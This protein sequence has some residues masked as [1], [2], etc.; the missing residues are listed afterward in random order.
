MDVSNAV[1]PPHSTLHASPRALGILRGV[2]RSFYLTLRVLPKSIRRPIGLAYLLARAADTIADTA[3]I[4]PSRRLDELERL[5]KHILTQNPDSLQL[6]SFIQNQQNRNEAHLLEQI[7]HVIRQFEALPTSDQ[8][9][10]REVLD[11]ITSGQILDL[12]RFP[13]ETGN[14][15]IALNSPEELDDYTWRVAGCVGVFWTR[16]CRAHLWPR[17]SLD[18]PLLE[19]LGIRFGKGLQLVN[20][21]R[22]VSR[23]VRNGRCYFPAQEL[24]RHKLHP[25]DLLQ[26]DCMPRFQPLYDQWL[27]R[28]DAFLE[29]GWTYTLSLP[30][31]T[32]RVH[33]ACAWPILIGRQTLALLEKNNPL[34]PS[35]RIRISRT[36]VRRILFH[37]LLAYPFARQWKKLFDKARG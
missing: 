10:I 2:S 28:A 29:D 4:P 6:S 13:P 9:H 32:P 27:R 35:R 23:D 33:L 17:T 22:D 18:W 20:I 26:P 37:S 16:I 15:L 8:G 24:A 36:S 12:Q 7:P 21:L 31:G 19:N 30:R 11:V 14:E 25:N 5:R 34:D 3:L 1:S